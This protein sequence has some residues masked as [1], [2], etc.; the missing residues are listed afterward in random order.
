MSIS[1][2]SHQICPICSRSI[3]LGPDNYIPFCSQRCQ[4]IDLG[5][6]LSDSYR[7]P[8]TLTDENK[9]DA[10]DTEASPDDEIQ[11]PEDLN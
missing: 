7:I 5:N 9:F 11:D 3:S 1:S 6:W 8:V 2:Q 10:E 4:T